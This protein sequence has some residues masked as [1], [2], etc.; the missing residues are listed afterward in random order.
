MLDV[1]TYLARLGYQGH[2]YIGRRQIPIHDFEP[3]THQVAGGVYVNNFIFEP[4]QP[5]G[6]KMGDE[7][8]FA[9]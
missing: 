4:Q 9:D 5:T 2:F 6:G 8:L 7:G 1:F 3:S